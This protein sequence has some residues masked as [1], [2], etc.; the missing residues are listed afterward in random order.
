MKL[1]ELEVKIRLETEER[2]Q[3]VFQACQL[4]YGPPQSHVLQLDQY[5]D[6]PDGQLKDQDLVI[7]IRSIGEQ[8]AIALKSPCIRLP[9]GLSSRIELEF[10]AAD[11]NVVCQQLVDQ[12]LHVR[13]SSEKERWMFVH[14]DLEISLDR[15]PFLGYFIEVEGPNEAAIHGVLHALKLPPDGAVLKHYGELMRDRFEELGMPLKGLQATFAA[16]D[17]WKKA[18]KQHKKSIK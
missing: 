3:Q 16:E 15:L 18:S 9:N 13:Q 17:A 11:G 7:R 6:T 4:L 8:Q 10:M 2:F 5:Y 1:N 14:K 12:G